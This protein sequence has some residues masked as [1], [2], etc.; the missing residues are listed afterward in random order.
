MLLLT[1]AVHTSIRI[2]YKRYMLNKYL[3]KNEWMNE[4]TLCMGMF[5]MAMEN[6]GYYLTYG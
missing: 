6:F 3:L 5:Y 2:S 1:A 4:Y